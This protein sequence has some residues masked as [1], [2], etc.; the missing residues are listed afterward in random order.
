MQLLENFIINTA[1]HVSGTLR[2]SSG[3]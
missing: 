3:A 2:Q 1:L